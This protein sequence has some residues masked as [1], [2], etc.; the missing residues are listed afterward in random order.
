MKTR[1]PNSTYYRNKA[2]KLFMAQFHGQPCE[3]CGN[4]Q[5]TCG[6]HIVAKSRSK[7]LRYDLRNIIVVCCRHHT[8]GNELAPHSVNQLA[9]ERFVE[10]F[11]LTFTKR[12][13]WIVE[14]EYIT[15]RYT[16]KQAAENMAAG[17][18]AWDNND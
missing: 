10:W 2:D 9:V 14:N 13:A 16:Y 4:D 5:G 12:H 8:M 3:V 11:K 1:S 7:A 15:R 17:R 6:H 18:K